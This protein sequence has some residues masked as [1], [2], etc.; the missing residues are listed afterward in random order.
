MNQES[1][2]VVSPRAP[3]FDNAEHLPGWRALS[4]RKLGHPRAS[5]KWTCIVPPV[6]EW[7]L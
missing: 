2:R 7:F 6:L 4:P 5:V 3:R 1:P